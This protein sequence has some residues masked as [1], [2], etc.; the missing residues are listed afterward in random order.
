MSPKKNAYFLGG[1][2]IFCCFMYLCYYLHFGARIK[3]TIV[4]FSNVI[5]QI[6]VKLVCNIFCSIYNNVIL[7]IAHVFINFSSVS[8]SSSLF[9]VIYTFKRNF[10]T[11]LFCLWF[12]RGTI[13]ITINID[14][15]ASFFIRN[16][17]RMVTDLLA[18][19]ISGTAVDF[20]GCYGKFYEMTLTFSSSQR[21]CISL[22]NELIG[23]FKLSI[24]N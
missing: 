20:F 21:K 7:V 3:L 6:M 4:S 23:S 13:I 16:I 8:G 5:R 17:L 10:N 1:R 9:I 19:R 14:G 18:R 24:N 11:T 22:C 12:Y 2:E 15:A